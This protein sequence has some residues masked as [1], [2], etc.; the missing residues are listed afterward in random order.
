MFSRELNIIS[1]IGSQPEAPT[2][3]G[4]RVTRQ[5][6]PFGVVAASLLKHSTPCSS[7][8]DQKAIAAATILLT[9]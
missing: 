1:V 3:A 2:E 5:L 6:N 7:I 4:R 8:E 9:Q